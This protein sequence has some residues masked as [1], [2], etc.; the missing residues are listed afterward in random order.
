MARLG[1]NDKVDTWYYVHNTDR[2]IMKLLKKIGGGIIYTETFKV[3][4]T[5]K[6]DEEDYLVYEL[7]NNNSYNLFHTYC[8]GK[9]FKGIPSGSRYCI[10]HK[11]E[12][13]EEELMELIIK[14][15]VLNYLDWKIN[16]LEKSLKE[17]ESLDNENTF[18]QQHIARESGI[19]QELKEVKSFIKFS[20]KE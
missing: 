17:C 2:R 8:W 3:E 18:K 16:T 1:M 9:L 13:V 7:N 19:V 10:G 20:L 4:F 12:K 15:N 14:D 6:P 5:N 11:L